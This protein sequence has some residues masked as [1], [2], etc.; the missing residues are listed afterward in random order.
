MLRQ[1]VYGVAAVVLAIGFAAA[2]AARADENDSWVGRAVLAKRPD[3]AL[4]VGQ[5]L[6]ARAAQLPQPMRVAQEQGDWLWIESAGTAGWLKKA[7]VTPVDQAER[8]FTDLLQSEPENAW[9]YNL[10][11]LVRE[12]QGAFEAAIEDFTRAIRYDAQ[13][14]SAY[15]NR[16]IARDRRGDPQRALEDYDAAIKLDPAYAAAYNNRGL[17]NANLGELKAAVADFDEAIRLD[18]KFAAALNNRG[19]VRDQTGDMQR[20]AQDFAAAIRLDAK[21]AEAHGNLGNVWRRQGKYEQAIEEFNQAVKFAP[22]DGAGYNNRAWMWATCPDEKFCDGKAAVQSAT[23]ACELAH[24][25]NPDWLDTLAASYAR[26]GDFKAA[27]KYQTQA[28]DLAPEAQQADMKT[29]LELYRQGKPFSES[30]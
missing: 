17:A 13:M 3:A 14:A 16:G 2:S 10:R 27:V 28:M 15:N 5:K 6:G 19:I 1:R 20:A 9:A 30:H 7:D 22:Q 12:Q 29:R 24:W 23:K 26:A 18:P 25:K 4:K 21:F 11:G 8:F